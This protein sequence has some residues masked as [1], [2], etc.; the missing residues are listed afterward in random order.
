LWI[1]AGG[2]AYPVEDVGGGIFV[3][4]FDVEAV[5]PGEAL[6]VVDAQGFCAR[7]IPRKAD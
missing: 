7:S 1:V 5:G 4:G 2:A 3:G 6:L